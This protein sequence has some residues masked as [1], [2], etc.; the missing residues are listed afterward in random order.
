MLAISYSMHLL[1]CQDS[2][3]ALDQLA[4][5]QIVILCWGHEIQFQIW[6]Q[7]WELELYKEMRQRFRSQSKQRFPL[8][9][10]FFGWRMEKLYQHFFLFFMQQLVAVREETFGSFICKPPGFHSYTPACPSWTIGRIRG[11]RNGTPTTKPSAHKHNIS[12]FLLVT[13]TLN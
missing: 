9:T 1:C 10:D 11:Q 3:G 4:D 5:A 13:Y 12:H 7:A 8:P 2:A 6:P